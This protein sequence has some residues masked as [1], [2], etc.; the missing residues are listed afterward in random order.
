MSFLDTLVDTKMVDTSI[1]LTTCMSGLIHARLK[2]VI[3]I[4]CLDTRL[5]IDDSLEKQD[6]QNVTM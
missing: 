2:I 5:L 4:P 1:F 3:G 6:R